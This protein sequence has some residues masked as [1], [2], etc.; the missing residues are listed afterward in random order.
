MNCLCAL[1][2]DPLLV[3]SFANIF[4]QSVG[5]LFVLFMGSFVVQKLFSLIRFYLFFCFYFQYCRR[6]IQK[7]IAAIYVK[8]HS[9]HIFL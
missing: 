5:Y 9:A 1:E 3:T 6:Q 7:N 8:E 4:S 2:I